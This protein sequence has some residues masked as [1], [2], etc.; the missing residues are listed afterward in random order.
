MTIV[1][2][3]AR[4]CLVTLLLA[5]ACPLAADEVSGD[6]A[7]VTSKS[8]QDDPQWGAVVRALSAKHQAPVVTYQDDVS[9]VVGPL[10]W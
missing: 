6:Y 8:T 5:V 7:V 3:S 2:R 9:E 10:G 1:R 4:L